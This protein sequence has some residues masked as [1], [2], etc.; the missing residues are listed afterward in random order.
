MTVLAIASITGHEA[1]GTARVVSGDGERRL[2]LVDLWVAPGAPDVRLYLTAHSDGTIDD[3]AID[4]GRVPD[5]TSSLT[6]AI[7]AGTDISRLSTVAVHCKVYS[8]DFGHGTLS[9]KGAQP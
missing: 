1:R 9:P 5:R 7:P 8:V 6:V 4:L 3:D 2:E